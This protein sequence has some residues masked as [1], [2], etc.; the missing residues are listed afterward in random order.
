MTW[1]TG[2][3]CDGGLF[4]EGRAMPKHDIIVV[5]ASAGGVEAIP[6]MLK[7]LPRTIPAAIFAVV[8]VSAKSP[9]V[10]PRILSR[11]T[12]LPAQH[13]RDGQ[14]I[15]NGNIYVAP[16][17]RHLLLEHNRIRVVRG[18][19]EN[20]HRPAVDP[21]FRSAARTFGPRVVG[22]ILTGALDDGTEGLE[23][24]KKCGGKTIVQSPEEA[25][26]PD[27]PL[28]AL[29]YV[30]VDH[31]LPLAK[32]GPL[33]LKLA[34]TAVKANGSDA[35]AEVSKEVGLIEA[36][37]TAQDMIKKLGPPSAFICPECSGP[38]WE[39]PEAEV[40][41]YRCLVG[42]AYS[43]ENLLASESES[44]ERAMWMAVR[45]LEE[46]ASLL[47]RLAERAEQLE[48]RISTTS[49]REQAEEHLQYATSLRAILKRVMPGAR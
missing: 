28:N 40:P 7:A 10:F 33:L 36:T 31:V 9:S 45:T 43:A 27:M 1:Q 35:C 46:R 15:E 3:R 39:S 13:P 24:V 48:Q 32:I 4:K 34:R 41:H 30:E 18:P 8:H 47:I 16:P 17:D 25:A 38:L 14:P 49:F 11:E 21:L 2:L 20:R 42:H 5:G 29:R 26:V 37:M 44:I 12:R 19:R 23:A 6:A 22:A